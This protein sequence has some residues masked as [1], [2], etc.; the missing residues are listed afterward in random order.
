MIMAKIV[1]IFL[2]CCVRV[3]K[4]GVILRGPAILAR[5]SRKNYSCLR[6]RT[7]GFVF[8]LCW[9]VRLWAVAQRSFFVWLDCYFIL[10]NLGVS[11]KKLFYIL[12]LLFLESIDILGK[13]GNCFYILRRKNYLMYILILSN[14]FSFYKTF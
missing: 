9:C 2:F 13:M 5:L 4:S 14:N 1:K 3:L 11:C 6:S 12:S 8:V 10:G 7:A